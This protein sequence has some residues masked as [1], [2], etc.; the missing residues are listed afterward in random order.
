M[1]KTGRRVKL[2]DEIIERFITAIKL[3]CPKKDACGAAGIG[4]STL[5]K[6]MAWADTDRDDAQRYTEFRERI[7]MAEGVAT[8][9]W[10]AVIERAA[11]D[12]SWQA[13]AWKLERRRGMFIPKMR[14]EI[15]GRDGES[16]RIESEAR[17]ARE[18]IDAAISRQD[19]LGETGSGVG[20]SDPTTTH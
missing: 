2:T 18:I 20:G 4:E 16:I 15:T 9:T 3:G 8:Q 14:T 5:Y 7:K 19:E 6:W 10:L 1:A 12:G 13:A 17:S 11:H